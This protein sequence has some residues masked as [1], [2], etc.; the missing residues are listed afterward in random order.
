MELTEKTISKKF[1][2]YGKVKTLMKEAFPN[3]G[4][5]PM[6][7][8]C[9][10]AKRKDASF[11]AYYDNGELCGVTHTV[12][13]EK[14]VFVSYL[15]VAKDLRSKGYGS[16]IIGTLKRKFASKTIYLTAEAPEPKS[17]NYSQRVARLK[18]YEKN[19]IKYTG[20]YNTLM[21]QKFVVLSDVKELC[22]E[23]YKRLLN[24]VLCGLFTP[25]TKKE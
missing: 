2:D 15:A 8:L 23:E 20:Y 13:D 5:A 12:E 10:R 24:R 11:T 17:K 7:L 18:F 21:S 19:G 3:F 16:E 4:Q 25:K 6:G 22:L 14:A 1:E 9:W